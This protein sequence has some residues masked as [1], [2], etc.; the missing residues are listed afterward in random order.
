MY[1]IQF[2]TREPIG[3]M[4]VGTFQ[5]EHDAQLWIDANIKEGGWIIKATGPDRPTMY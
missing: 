1:V 2:L 4:E 5:T 3:P